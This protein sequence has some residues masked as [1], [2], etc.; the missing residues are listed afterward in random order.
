VVSF[1]L[2]PLPGGDAFFPGECEHVLIGLSPWNGRYSRRYIEALV[3]W[4]HSRFPR[5]D[6]FTP[7]WEA[8]HTL[9]AAGV[10]T[11][12]A[13]HR[14]RRAGS[15]L[16]NPALRALRD[17][18]V[19]HPERQVH[20]WT[21]LHARL[22]YTGARRRVQ[23]AYETDPAVRRA[24]RETARE[25]VRGAGRAEPDECAIDLAVGYALAELPLVTD[26]PA[27]F[28][29][30]SSVFLYHR[31]MELIRP[32]ING[33]STTLTPHAGQKYAIATWKDE[34]V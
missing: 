26:A 13:V 2:S 11:G 24:C 16:R 29:A 15:K 32:L 18:G 12:D 22:A 34:T 25:A 31:D 7:G 23:L 6:V 20:S 33:E 3:T 10:P 9:V 30:A 21:Q 1:V 5:V 27:V 28:G 19:A 17:A 8:A 4:A 14:A